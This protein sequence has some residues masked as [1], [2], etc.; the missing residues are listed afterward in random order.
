MKLSKK[1]ELVL[2][3]NNEYLTNLGEILGYTIESRPTTWQGIKV[4]EIT[5]KDKNPNIRSTLYFRQS[6]DNY[7]KTID[8]ELMSLLVLS[9]SSRMGGASIIPQYQ[10]DFWNAFE[11]YFN[12]LKFAE[13][14]QNELP[15]NNEVKQSSKRINGKV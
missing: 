1:A 7:T 14:L 15:I 13:N 8:D 5:I 4:W 3:A 12:A 6:A 9:Q 11:K 2:E 10:K